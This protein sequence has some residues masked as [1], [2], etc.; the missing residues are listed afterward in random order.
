MRIDLDVVQE[1][2]EKYLPSNITERIVYGKEETY[3]EGTQVEAYYI[4]QLLTEQGESVAFNKAKTG[5]SIQVT[6]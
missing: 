5:Y 1:V 3:F 6:Q 4:V 2:L